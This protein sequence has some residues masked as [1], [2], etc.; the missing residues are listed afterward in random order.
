MKAIFSTWFLLLFFLGTS[1]HNLCGQKARF[2]LQ[3]DKNDVVAGTFFRL[4]AILEN[5]DADN[6]QLGNI[7]PF[8]VVQG[9]SRSSSLSIINGN[10]SESLT[11]VW[12]IKAPEVGT[13]TIAPATVNIG[14][15]TFSSNTLRV[16]VTDGLTNQPNIQGG[17]DLVVR[18]ETNTKIAYPGQQVV[19]DLVL[20]T[21]V[22]VATYEVLNTIETRG[23]YIKMAEN[24]DFPTQKVSLGG[25]DY[26]SKVLRRYFVF[27]QKTGKFMINNLQ[28]SAHVVSGTGMGFSIFGDT[29][30]KELVSN[31]L[32]FNV[33]DIPVGAPA[34]FSGAVG[35]FSISCSTQSTSIPKGGTAILTIL[36]EGDGDPKK[37]KNPVIQ[38]PEGLDAF[39]PVIKKDE[40]TEQG[41]QMRM[42]REVEY[43]FVPNKDTVFSFVPVFNYFSTITKQ[44]EV[45]VGDTITWQIVA[46]DEK[47]ADHQMSTESVLNNGHQNPVRAYLANIMGIIWKFVLPALILL[48][49]IFFFG[50][51]WK[52]NKV[53]SSA[54]PEPVKQQSMARIHL[55]AAR[56]YQKTGSADS[57]LRE[58]EM[59][60]LAKFQEHLSENLRGRS[61]NEI[62][63]I[64]SQK[65]YTQSILNQYMQISR[66]IDQLRFGGSQAITT[67]ILDNVM[68]FMEQLDDDKAQ[69]IPA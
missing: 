52:H 46:E 18:L 54:T 1:N 35:N 67:D 11:Y 53:V 14:S 44:Y 47:T 4:E 7:H 36:L 62:L 61:R 38:A 65:G 2:Y 20:Y 40:W 39:D 9:P 56:F 12:L 5:M 45:V 32:E 43:T 28:V 17:A 60:M 16:V 31:S 64:L 26:Y 49:F 51:K 68:Q 10:R 33:K 13:Y 6:I 42:Y 55:D 50:K 30:Q 21:A 27:P 19:L 63:E 34:H 24:T 3:S 59:A 37:C 58:L 29:Y 57:F 48:I 23:L 15:R 8:K 25:R 41:G 66:I 69:N 22:E